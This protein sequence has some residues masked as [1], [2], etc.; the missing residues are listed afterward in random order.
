MYFY[1]RFFFRSLYLRLL[2]IRNLFCSFN[3]DAINSKL[4]LV[5][6]LN[7]WFISRPVISNYITSRDLHFKYFY[8]PSA[9]ELSCKGLLNS[10]LQPYLEGA[11]TFSSHGFRPFRT[12]PDVLIE[13]KSKLIF[14]YEGNLFFAS[15]SFSFTSIYF[16]LWIT[17][18]LPFKHYFSSLTNNENVLLNPYFNDILNSDP[19]S[20][21]S[22]SCFNLVFPFINL[23]VV[24]LVWFIFLYFGRSFVSILFF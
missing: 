6:N 20:Y 16:R 5:F 14:T 22:N 4:Q 23:S 13:V 7:K 1:K 17:K 24:G 10:I 11:Y 9:Y 3:F 18:N 12:L 2:I 21:D 19:F 8:F 15:N